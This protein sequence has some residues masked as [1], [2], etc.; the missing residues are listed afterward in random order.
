MQDP[1]GANCIRMIIELKNL[2]PKN[3]WASPNDFFYDGSL[4]NCGSDFALMPSK[5][6][7]G[8]IV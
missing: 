3:F 5:F 2:F 1:Y 6:E 8:G 7:P 4:L